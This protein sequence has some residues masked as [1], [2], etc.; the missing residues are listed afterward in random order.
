MRSPK[1]VFSIKVTNFHQSIQHQDDE[2]SINECAILLRN[3]A[4]VRFS[5]VLK[6]GNNQAESPLVDLTNPKSVKMAPTHA[7]RHEKSG[8]V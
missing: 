6:Q 5:L 1:I 8:S 4:L 2:S 7:M 3:K